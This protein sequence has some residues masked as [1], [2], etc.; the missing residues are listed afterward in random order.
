MVSPRGLPVSATIS[1]AEK[2]IMAERLT[3]YFVNKACLT[4]PGGGPAP[5]P[6]RATPPA[7]SMRRCLRW[8]HSHLARQGQLA[9][10]ARL[11][12]PSAAK[13]KESIVAARATKEPTPGFSGSTMFSPAEQAVACEIYMRRIVQGGIKRGS[14]SPDAEWVVANCIVHEPAH[15]LLKAKPPTLAE[16]HKLK[17]GTIRSDAGSKP[18]TKRDRPPVPAVAPSEQASAA[19]APRQNPMPVPGPPDFP[20]ESGR[21]TWH[22]PHFVTET[23]RCA[24]WP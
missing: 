18:L 19:W 5:L 20:V 24:G 22:A 8:R 10:A 21:R 3:L 6:C 17:D 14:P 4:K 13:S 23:T 16:G 12:R 2:V 7:S 11:C 1:G 9:K 15:A